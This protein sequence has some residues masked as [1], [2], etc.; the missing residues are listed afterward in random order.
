MTK[1]E[2]ARGVRI[3]SIVSTFVVR[4]NVSLLANR[5][6]VDRI[7]N[8]VGPVRLPFEAITSQQ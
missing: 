6:Y 7:D 5:S 8:V 4:F 3:S 2:Q 1:I